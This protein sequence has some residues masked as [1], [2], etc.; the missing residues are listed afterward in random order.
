MSA[1]T[2]PC[3]VWCQE[4]LRVCTL[5]F[6]KPKHVTIWNQG[7]RDWD[8]HPGY[9]VIHLNHKCFTHPHRCTC[10]WVTHT[11][12]NWVENR[13]NI[14]CCPS[15]IKCSY[16]RTEQKARMLLYQELALNKEGYSLERHVTKYILH[17]RF[18]AFTKTWGVAIFL[19]CFT[20]GQWRK[21]KGLKEM[22]D[23]WTAIESRLAGI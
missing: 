18:K 11:K 13:Q 20:N 22:A 3:D 14:L 15:E 17:L 19:E 4:F 12:Q 1:T 23:W 16:V 6:A 2:L 9:F 10:T 8:W 21:R 7:R 5:I